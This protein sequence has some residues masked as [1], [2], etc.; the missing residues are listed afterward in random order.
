MVLYSWEKYCGPLRLNTLSQA[1][2]TVRQTQTVILPWHRQQW[3]KNKTNKAWSCKSCSWFWAF[4]S[5][6]WTWNCLTI[7]KI[8]LRRSGLPLFAVL[9]IT[10]KVKCAVQTDVWYVVLGINT[11]NWYYEVL[12]ASSY[13]TTYNSFVCKMAG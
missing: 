3:Q 8:C 10:K 4:R 11:P 13:S 1:E 9:V 5:L 7:C 6:T 12:P 2:P